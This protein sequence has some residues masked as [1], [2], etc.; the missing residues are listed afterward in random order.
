MQEPAAQDGPAPAKTAGGYLH[1]AVAALRHHALLLVAAAAVMGFGQAMAALTGR[2]VSVSVL[3]F[4]R[5]YVVVA[6]LIVVT[7]LV[8]WK[9][10][11][12]ALVERPPNPSRHMLHWLHADVFSSARLVNG[13]VAMT[14][15]LLLMTGFTRAKNTAIGFAGYNWD[16][17]WEAL[18]RTLHLGVL[19]QDLLAPLFGNAWMSRFIDL[20]YVAWYPF[21]FAALLV[22]AFQP[23]RS[24]ARHRYLLAVIFTIGIGG[25][26]LAVALSSGGPVYF[27]R[28]TGGPDPYAP[29][30]D[31]LRE[32]S[33]HLPLHAL[34]I[35]QS[36]WDERARGGTS[37]ISAMPSMHVAIAAL[38]AMA[39]W[40]FGGALRVVS[41]GFAALVLLGS[42]HLGWHYAVD[43]Y[44]GI[45]IAWAAWMAALPVSRWYLRKTGDLPPG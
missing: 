17:Q 9:F 38:V 29:L 25:C 15:I 8:I 40:S 22:G 45:L 23:L 32:A 11:R 42:I 6:G 26:V 21:L 43:G 16:R 44:A 3:V 33:R 30:M 31:M 37:F 35:Q 19:P 27:G 5:N 10:G 14:A 2:D 34:E 28:L 20:V 24:L 1:N 7:A 36:L 12:M 4:I 41:S 18:D 13:A 39:L